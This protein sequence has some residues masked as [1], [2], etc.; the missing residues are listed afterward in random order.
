MS[1]SCLILKTFLFLYKSLLGFYLVA[2]KTGYKNQQ[3]FSTAFKKKYG[4]VPSK[5]KGR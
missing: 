3:H 4:I 2:E 5:I 1:G